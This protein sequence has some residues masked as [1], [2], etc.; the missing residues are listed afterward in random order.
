M[1]E[2]QN[3]E[4]SQPRASGDLKRR[5]MEAAPW[6]IIID[7]DSPTLQDIL[8]TIS[9]PAGPV[10]SLVTEP[11]GR[12]ASEVSDVAAKVR[13]AVEKYQGDTLS[14]DHK[15]RLRAAIGDAFVRLLALTYRSGIDPL[16]AVAD[17]LN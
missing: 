3:Y 11:L 5:S 9:D 8:K 16:R 1:S 14:A 6:L 7:K 17:R 12:L 13:D 2:Q 10:P 4:P 15:A